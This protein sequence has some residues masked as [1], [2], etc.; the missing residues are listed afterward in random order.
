MNTTQIDLSGFYG[1]EN[2][3]RWSPITRS[4][5]SD[6][7]HYLAET[8]QAYWLFDAIDSHLTTRGVT[9]ETEFTVA[10]LSKFGC[11]DFKLTLDDGNGNIYVKQYIPYSDFPLT[12]IKLYAVFN[13]NAWTHMLPSE[14]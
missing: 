10:I 9:D 4:V 3:I 12:E 1:S 5:L 8:A 11:D 7:A 6:G 2:L 14:Y 13:G